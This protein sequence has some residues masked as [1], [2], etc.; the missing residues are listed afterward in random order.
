MLA[1][2]KVWLMNVFLFM[3]LFSCRQVPTSVGTVITVSWCRSVRGGT[4]LTCRNFGVC[5]M[6]CSLGG[7]RRRRRS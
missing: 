2:P 7:V 3:M 5:V 4:R 1:A 6:G